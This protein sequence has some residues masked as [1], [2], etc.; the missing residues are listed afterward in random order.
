[1]KIAAGIVEPEQIT[2]V[3]VHG[4]PRQTMMTPE[5]SPESPG[6]CKKITIFRQVLE[7]G[8]LGP[9]S[10]REDSAQQKEN[11][12]LPKRWVGA[13]VFFKPYEQE[14]HVGKRVAAR[15]GVI[16]SRRLC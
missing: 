9:V 4:V 16:L 12:A 1:M 3:R 13:T 15:L 2:R 14:V 8:K 6:A 7:D 10:H 11:Q 5:E